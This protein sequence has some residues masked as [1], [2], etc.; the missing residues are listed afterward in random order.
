MAEIETLEEV[1]LSLVDVK[2]ALDVINKRDKALSPKGTKVLDYIA[3][4]TSL[5]Q[6][7]AAEI[8]KKLL[9]CNIERLKEKQM[10]KILDIMPKDLDSLKAVLVGDNLTLR[11]EDLK[12]ILECLK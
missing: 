4:I 5:K 1:P 6:K 2:E 9:E 10:S 12:K 3:K 7:E 8:R 11:Q